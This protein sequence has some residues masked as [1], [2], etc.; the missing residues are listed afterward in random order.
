MTYKEDDVMLCTVERINS[1]VVFVKL[2]DNS[3]GTI[4]SSEIAAGRI[5]NM[6]QYVVPHKKI[7]CKVLQ[8]KGNNIEL[9]LRR[10]NAKEKKQVMQKH[11][12]EQTAKS[13]IHSIL[14]NQ[15]EQTEKEILKNFPSL[16]E[17]FNQARENSKLIEKYIPKKFQQSIKKI[18]Q[19][20]QKRVNLSQK[21]KLK[22]L[23]PD[24]IKKIKKIFPQDKEIKITYISAGEFRVKL[25]A[26]NYKKGNQKMQKILNTIKQNAKT[27]K[28]DFSS[29]EIKSR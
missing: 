19:K 29:E 27:N 24:G 2:P 23:E 11:K 8:V 12:Q 4:I 22:C 15:A 28:C 16:S 10:V 9:S 5:K 17:F 3:E 25:T 1:N 20:K 18:T 21:V 14:K 6:R 7:A 13:A 26:D